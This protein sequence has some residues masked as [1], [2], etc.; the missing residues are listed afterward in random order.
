MTAIAPDV[1][2]TT[3][4]SLHG[5]AE[6]VVASSRFHAT[7]TMRLRSLPGGFATVVPHRGID[8]LAVVGTNLVLTRPDGRSTRWPFVGTD[9]APA[10]AAGLPFGAFWNQPF[11]ATRLLRDRGGEAAVP[12][13]EFVGTDGSVNEVDLLVLT[14]GGLRLLELKHWR[15]VA[16]GRRCRSRRRLHGWRFRLPGGHP[17]RPAPSTVRS[18]ARAAAAPCRTSSR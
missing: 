11:G 2:V 15:G 10:A 13:V 18:M 17:G 3:R 5:V 14:P 1:L 12:N 6:T 8:V 7:G 9:Q 4:R 16:S